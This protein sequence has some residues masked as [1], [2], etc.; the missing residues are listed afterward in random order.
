MQSNKGYTTFVKYFFLLMAIQI[1]GIGIGGYFFEATINGVDRKLDIYELCIFLAIAVLFLVLWLAIKD[2]M[3]IVRLGGQNI[4]I[5][6]GVETETVNWLDVERISQYRFVMPP[7]YKLK[8]KNDDQTY[9]FITQPEHISFG[10]GVTDASSM[11]A[12]I[13]RKKSELG[14]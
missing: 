10:F 2:R 14:I 6:H 8:I 7:M 12:F 4:T 3:V 13:E 5:N 9:L 11:G 1:G